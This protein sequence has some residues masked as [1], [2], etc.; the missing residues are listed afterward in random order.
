M[1]ITIEPAHAGPALEEARALILE[2]ADSLG[3]DLD[4]EGFDDEL[5]GLPGAYAPPGGRLLLARIDGRPAGCVAVRPFETDVCEMKRLYVRP[6]ARG[7]GLGRRLAE[8]VIAGA[9]S[10]GYRSMRLDTLAKL[11][12][13]RELYRSLG[14][15]PIPP[16]R[17]NPTPGVI[18]LEL[19]LARD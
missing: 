12:A 13:A 10:S 5:A 19:D 17:H 1:T 14:F 9:R 8:D 2:Y 18:F 16:Y 6:E 4:Y 11:E 7:T 15:Q 3:I